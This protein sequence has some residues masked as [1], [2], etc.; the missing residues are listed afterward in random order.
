[1]VNKAQEKKITQ[2]LNPIKISHHEYKITH[3]YKQI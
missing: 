1:M 3:I 2:F